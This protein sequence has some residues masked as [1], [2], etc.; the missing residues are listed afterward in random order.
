MSKK[1]S[2]NKLWK[3]PNNVQ[4]TADKFVTD[5]FGW[6]QC[7]VQFAKWRFMYDRFPHFRAPEIYINFILFDNGSTVTTHN[8]YL[9]YYWDTPNK[10]TQ[11]FFT[12]KCVTDYVGRPS[13]L[14]FRTEQKL[15]T[16]SSHSFGQ[17]VGT[18]Y[19]KES[20]ALQSRRTVYWTYEQY[21]RP[22]QMF[23][24]LSKP[25]RTHNVRLWFADLLAVAVRFQIMP[26]PVLIVL[27]YL[28]RRHTSVHS[29]F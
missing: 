6:R 20:W 11:S 16:F 5:D 21:S 15:W 27:L 24:L 17:R 22:R 28:L 10:Y 29:S 8:Q 2:C 1:T 18:A 26:F 7:T 12:S 14:R 4:Y 9:Y 23:A 3:F 19:S 13:G 25:I